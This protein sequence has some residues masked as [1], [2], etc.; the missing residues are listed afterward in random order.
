MVLDFVC[1]LVKMALLESKEPLESKRPRIGKMDLFAQEMRGETIGR[2]F[3]LAKKNVIALRQRPLFVWA[4][5]PGVI[6]LGIDP[7]G[8]GKTS[9]TAIMAISYVRGHIVVSQHTKYCERMAIVNTIA[10]PNSLSCFVLALVSNVARA[11]IK[12][13]N[14]LRKMGRNET[15]ADLRLLCCIK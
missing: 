10:S 13:V 4:R 8:G 3:L 15:S 1:L 14:P 9:E 11:T 7:H 12:L 5:P 6:H 2:S